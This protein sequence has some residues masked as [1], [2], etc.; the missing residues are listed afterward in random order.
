MSGDSQGRDWQDNDAPEPVEEN[1]VGVSRVRLAHDIE[2]FFDRIS[3][4][5]LLSAAIIVSLMP[6]ELGVGADM[7]FLAI[8]GAEFLG[9]L[10]VVAYAHRGD[11]GSDDEVALGGEDRGPSRLGSIALLVVDLIALISFIP[12]PVSQASARWLRL[13]RL[14]R[15]ALLVGYWAPLVR[16]VWA[17][18]SRRERMRQIALMGFVVGGLSFAGAVFLH[19]VGGTGV[20]SNGDGALTRADEDFSLMLWWAFRQVQDPGNIVQSP[21]AVPLLLTSAALTLFGLFMVSFLIGLGTDVVRELLERMQL[22][23]PGLRGHTVIVNITPST[24]RL[25]HELMRY[26]KRVLPTDARLFSLRWFSELRKGGLTAAKYLV[27]G[28]R[29]EP[30]DFL[31]QPE[32]SKIVYRERCE[33][34]EMLIARADLLSAKRIVLLA[35]PEEAAPD[36]ST[37]TTLLT[38][39]ERI[40]A[41][42]RLRPELASTQQRVVIAEI[43]D[44]SNVAAARAAVRTGSESFRAFV[45]PT[46]RLLA[47]FVAGVVRRPGLGDLLEELLTSKGHELYTCFFDAE[48]LGFSLPESPSLDRDQRVVMKELLGGALRR[49]REGHSGVI[50]L[51]LLTGAIGRSGARDFG[52][53]INPTGQVGEEEIIGVVAIAAGFPAVSEF[54]ESLVEPSPDEEATVVPELPEFQAS[55]STKIQHAL[56]CGFRPGSIYVIEELLRGQ[57]NG[58][59]LVLVQTEEAVQAVRSALVSHSQ[60]VARGLMP[61]RHAL[62]ESMP[63]G[64]FCFS[65]PGDPP[66]HTSTVFVRAA[67]WMESRHMVDLP[68]PDF[69]HVSELDAIVFVADEDGSA[70]P[71]TTTALLKLEA[72]FGSLS[73]PAGRPRVVAEVFD[74]RLAARL[75]AHCSKVGRHHVRIYSVQALRAFFLFQSVVVPGFDRVY[76]ELL[77]SWGQSF[78]RLTPPP[79]ASG[80]CT[81]EGLALGLAERGC[82]LVAVQF[83]EP[84]PKGVLRVASVPGQLRKEF[85]L[86]EVGWV[87]AIA[88]DGIDAETTAPAAEPAPA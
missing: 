18:L 43:L 1:G 42:E 5:L 54:A 44:E 32:L 27:V 77:G 25:L 86:S 70:D 61:A 46:E 23:P 76:S 78:V 52:V 12:L 85:D 26:Y 19:S 81:T 15:M 84:G 60:L 57:N 62:F 11:D 55:H 58:Q 3:V 63:D 74:A 68:H 59:V 71:R 30:P 49:S 64:S 4:R 83:R 29:A 39:V 9:R 75:Q 73:V 17:I 79:G 36:A 21:H 87:W 65:C 34:D 16:D 48:G 22:R 14:T 88:P 56:V 66:G 6:V 24:R 72:L 20:D 13:F 69:G 41:R 45:V 67:D 33:E 10:Y 31:R 47:L 8:F 50:P 28:E 51:G 37:I 35:D 38:F 82:V 40:A 7:A 2:H 80:P 53:A